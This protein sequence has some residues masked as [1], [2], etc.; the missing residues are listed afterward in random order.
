MIKTF[1]KFGLAWLIVAFSLAASYSQTRAVPGKNF[2]R[3]VEKIP[4]EKLPVENWIRP[5]TFRAFHLDHNLARAALKNAPPEFSAGKTAPENLEIEIPMPDGSLAKFRVVESPV[6]AP[7]LAAKFPEIKTYLGHGL[8]DPA[9]TARLD[10]TP[11]GFHAQI[12]SPHG[13]VYIEPLTKGE[14]NLYS[15]FYKRDYERDPTEFHCLT[16]ADANAAPALARDAAAP[17]FRG[18]E[19]LRTYRIAVAA[20]GEYT[21]F[22]GGSVNAALAAIV[23]AINRVDGIYETELAVRFVLVDH[24]DKIIFT[25]AGNDPYSA[26]AANNDTMLE[27]QQTMDARIGSAN[28]DF[29]IAL[30]TAGSGVAQVHT[31]CQ[32][33]WKAR[34]CVGSTSPIGDGFYV[35]YL[36]HEI[37]HQF[38]ALHTFN[39]I[40]GHCNN[41]T[42]TPGSAYEPGSGSTIMAY[43]GICDSDNLQVHSDPYFHSTSLQEIGDYITSGNGNSCPTTAST[44]NSPP[45][46]DAGGSYT[47]PSRTPFRLTASGG[48][49]NGDTVLYCWEERDLGPA[50]SLNDGDNGSSP[51]FRSFNPTSEA[52]RSFPK[53]SDILRG[54]PG[55]GERLPT[56]DRTLNFRVTARD[57]RGGSSS[58][59]TQVFVA[60]AAGPFQITSPGSR[61]VWFGLTTQTITW[62]VAGTASSPIN[63]G[64][65]NILF[66][67]DGTNFSTTLA[68]W[69]SN[70]GSAQ[71]TLPNDATSSARLAVAPVGNIFFAISPEEIELRESVPPQIT[72]QPESHRIK[73][74]AT[75]TCRVGVEATPP[76][77]YQW[78]FND[79]DIPGATN[80]TLAIDVTSAAQRGFYRVIVTNPAGTVAS[81]EAEMDVV[82]EAIKPS[83]SITF[84]AAHARLSNETVVVRGQASDNAAISGVRYQLNGGE[85]QFAEGANNWSAEI[86]PVPGTNFFSVVSIDTSGNES[87]RVRRDFFC[88]VTSV[89][90]VATNGFGAVTPNLNG[91]LLE[92]G[93]DFKMRATPGRGQIFAGWSG[94]LNETNATIKFRMRPELFLQANFIPNPFIPV[95]GMYRGLVFQPDNVQHESS[96]AFSLT[97]AEQ[98]TFSSSFRV[99]GVRYAFTG[100][101]DLEGNA[102]KTLRRSGKNPLTLQLH[103]DLANGTDQ[104][105]GNLSDGVWNSYLRGDRKL[106]NA[107]TNPAPQAGRYTMIISGNDDSSTSPGGH[108]IGFITIDRSGAIR[109]AGTLADGTTISQGSALSKNGE[110]P[111]YVLLYSSKGFVLSWITV[112]ADSSRFEAHVNWFKPPLRSARYPGGFNLSPQLFGSRY[113]APTNHEPV[114][115]FQ[116]GNVTLSGGELPENLNASLILSNNVFRVATNTNKVKLLL[117]LANGAVGGSFIHPVTK[118]TN[119][120]KGVVLP[121]FHEA[122]GFFLS[123]HESGRVSVTSGE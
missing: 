28:Y 76:I 53:L 97:A 88:V 78:Q 7:E 106:F 56:A 38:G 24:E 20:A 115:N 81:D 94:D 119:S 89:L 21:A 82:A 52:S 58:S 109:F 8:D 46:V 1:W 34:A 65:V 43:A 5:K 18:G 116:N 102:T 51:L 55:R 36:A 91:R 73:P 100:R 112:S 66:A 123:P 49:P 57:N 13:A 11:A 54:N 29:G 48:D 83:V 72:A 90:T 39:S 59:D 67:S 12:L 111:F 70:N 103:L 16:E 25:N 120:I 32:D 23:T 47:I 35:D 68:S 40:S 87:P 14:T 22:Q 2:W 42:R 122:D 117:N 45:N 6:M 15:C 86:S 33:G 10:Y 37:G 62:D 60:G 79:N 75:V 92:I 71:V 63:A 121:S 26:N 4:P 61:V 93:R 110:W 41:S 27:N 108:G 30:N 105:T 118:K 44:G 74:R 107:K 19:T 17:M 101:F 77:S 31:V 114:L 95:K 99:G 3:A 69:I 64:A 84:P 113:I 50:Q 96:G 9:A 98:G 80:A 104:I 85:P